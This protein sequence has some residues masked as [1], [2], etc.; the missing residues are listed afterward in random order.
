VY[1]VGD[2]PAAFYVV[3]HGKVVRD[4]CNGAPPKPLNV[5]AYFGEVGVLLQHTKCFATV[6]A[7]E[8]TSLLVI[9]REDFARVMAKE[10]MARVDPRIGQRSL[11]RTLLLEM[12]VKL[13]RSDVSMD[14]VLAYPKTH[15]VFVGFALPMLRGGLRLGVYNE[16]AELL[17]RV[18]AAIAELPNVRRET[19]LDIEAFLYELLGRLVDTIRQDPS[20]SGE[21]I[22]GAGLVVLSEPLSGA[23]EAARSAECALLD[24]YDASTRQ[25]CASKDI[26]KMIAPLCRR[27]DELLR[28]AYGEFVASPT[29]IELLDRMGA[30]A[31]DVKSA[32]NMADL[33][34]AASHLKAERSVKLL[35][36]ANATSTPGRAVKVVVKESAS[37]AGASPK[38]GWTSAWNKANSA[39]RMS[40]RLSRASSADLAEQVQAPAPAPA[41]PVLAGSSSAKESAGGS[42]KDQS[43]GALRARARA[44]AAR[45]NAAGSGS[46]SGPTTTSGSMLVPVA[47]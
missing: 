9:S 12:L 36:P 5:G 17:A 39:V 29:F 28:L 13:Q 1:S 30:Y 40:I 23:L 46:T 6:K 14:V 41:R 31:E 11:E 15:R 44:N 19:A 8:E 38:K 24:A 16:T 34:E 20:P 10:G 32:I 18:R 22:Q 35:D 26:E 33:A 47:V 27:F 37:G 2:E 43:A 7:A 4:Y 21:A 3:A 45:A 42:F 25:T